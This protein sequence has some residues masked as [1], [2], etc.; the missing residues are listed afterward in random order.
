MSKRGFTAESDD[1]VKAVKAAKKEAGISASEDVAG[2]TGTQTLDVKNMCNQCQQV[3]PDQ[4]K[5]QEHAQ[6]IH[7]PTRR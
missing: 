6:N 7:A 1:E 2:E 3:F 5:L 4:E